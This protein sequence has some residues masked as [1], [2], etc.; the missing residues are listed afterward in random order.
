MGFM[1]FGILERS[2]AMALTDDEVEMK[3]LMPR[4]LG[5]LGWIE[6]LVGYTRGSFKSYIFFRW[7]DD[8]YHDDNPWWCG[9]TALF[10]IIW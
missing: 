10:C 7:P 2:W 9:H 6:L 1:A 3:S 5:I 4:L 8:E